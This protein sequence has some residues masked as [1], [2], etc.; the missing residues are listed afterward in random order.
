VITGGK[1]VS[2]KITGGNVTANGV[3]FYN[4]GSAYNAQTGLPDSGDGESPPPAPGT[5]SFGGVVIN[6]SIAMKPFNDPT[7]PF[8]GMLLYQRRRNTQSIEIQGN[9]AAGNLAGTLYARW[10]LFKIAG[11][12]TYKAQFVTGSMRVTGTGDVSIN[13][14]G[15]DLGK[16]NQVFLVE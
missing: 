10:S 11:Q 15:Q 2:L 14:A 3:M 4:T 16:G 5:A 13:Y 7:S 8:D 6:A 1:S 9:S 12:G